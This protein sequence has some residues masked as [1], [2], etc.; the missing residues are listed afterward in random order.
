MEPF[1]ITAKKLNQIIADS[2]R[3]TYNRL[4]VE[5]FKATGTGWLETVVSLSLLTVAGS[6]AILG[7]RCCRVVAC[8]RRGGGRVSARTLSRARRKDWIREPLPRLV[9]H[10]SRARYV[11]CLRQ[12]ALRTG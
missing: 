8:V 1:S 4:L 6:E 5:D 7:N 3:R 12:R 9:L 2:N 11:L 10:P